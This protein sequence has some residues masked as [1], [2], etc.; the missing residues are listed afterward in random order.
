MSTTVTT[1]TGS[2]VPGATATVRATATPLA[3]ERRPSAARWQRFD[4]AAAPPQGG[5]PTK[6]YDVERDE[7]WTVL[8]PNGEG[9]RFMLSPYSDIAIGTTGPPGDGE[10]VLLDLQSGTVTALL[11]RWVNFRGWPAATRP[12]IQVEGT[13]PV[14][15]ELDLVP[16]TAMPLDT[17]GDRVID[18]RQFA[19]PLPPGGGLPGATHVDL[20]VREDGARLELVLVAP[21]AER[22]VASEQG[23]VGIAPGNR[24]ATVM[25]RDGGVQLVDFY[26]GRVY[27]LGR[28]VFSRAHSWSPDGR[29]LAIPYWEG[30]THMTVAFDLQAL[31]GAPPRELGRYRDALLVDWRRDGR[32]ALLLGEYCL[33]GGF[34]LD[35]LDLGTGAVTRVPSASRGSWEQAWSPAGDVIAVSAP[36]DF[37]SLIDVATGARLPTPAFDAS[38]TRMQSIV[39][40]SASGRWLALEDVRGS[41]RCIV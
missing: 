25:A 3:L 20:V 16:A 4:A 39:G 5:P 33:P 27:D 36:D 28:Y 7:L 24:V 11:P 22:A 6:F 26:G 9:Y 2:G 19:A 10:T 40:W 34:A 31:P 12:L 35:R 41:D 38:V 37:V 18:R 8:G 13:R 1:V 30:R 23:F 29:Y 21:G 15:Y 32:E 14:V 17:R